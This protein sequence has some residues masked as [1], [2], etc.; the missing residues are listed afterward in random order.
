MAAPPRGVFAVPMVTCPKCN[1]RMPVRST[2]LGEWAQCLRCVHRFIP[3]EPPPEA[4]S[5]TG[6]LRVVAVS[7]GVLATL[8]VAVWLMVR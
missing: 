3:G 8:A 5:A 6:L 7:T 4:W 1:Y 2:N